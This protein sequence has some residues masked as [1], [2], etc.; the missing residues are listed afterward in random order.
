M[1]K[2]NIFLISALALGFA[3]CDDTSDLG[4]MQVNPQEEIMSADGMT[5]TMVAP[6]TGDAIKMADYAGKMIPVVTYTTD[7]TFPQGAYVGFNLEVATNDKYSDAITIP[8]QK[9]DD[10]TYGVEGDEWDSAFRHLLGKAPYT[11]DNYIR[12]SAFAIIDHQISRIGT[13]N[14]WFGTKK[15]AVTP[16]DLNI[17]VEEAYYLVGT[18]CDWKL[19]NAVKFEHSDANQYDDPVFTLAV[20]I[21]SDANGF[22][23]KIVPQSAYE[24][25]DWDSLYGTEINGDTAT[26]GVLYEGGE[27]GC[28]NVAGQYLFTINMLDCTYT[29]TQAIPMLYTPGNGNGWGFESGWL[30]TWDFT[31]YFGF[32]HLNGG[33]K[34]T[35]RPAWGGIEWGAGSEDGKLA[36]GGGD[37][38]GP[39]NGLYWMNVNIAAETY[40]WTKIDTIGIIGGFEGNDWTSDEVE[41]T[42][43]A[44]FLTW[45][46][47]VTFTKA[48]TEWKFRTNGG[49]GHPNLGNSFD[50][51]NDDGANLGVPADGV[52]TYDVTLHL[53]TVPY[54]VTFVKK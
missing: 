44:D 30:N 10:K 45:T 51:L 34:I 11:K 16:V 43:S 20:D 21:P 36:V 14:T 53:A 23:W 40:S 9:I 38:K 12:V 31:N 8:M 35:D 46:G 18:I 1:K 25:Q 47:T 6:A 54:T 50:E 41:L 26:E 19:E 3:A 7:N 17:Q 15:I 2:L 39:E 24:A 4:V 13:D 22:W 48:N 28:L 5:V 52:G 49:W 29:V 27:A 32:T 42:P 37:I 33:F